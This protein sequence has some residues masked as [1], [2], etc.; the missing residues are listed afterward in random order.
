MSESEENLSSA[1]DKFFGVKT[2]HGDLSAVNNSSDDSGIEV[3]V[4]QDASPAQEPDKK[5]VPL[6]NYSKDLTDEELASYSEGVQKRINQ[7]T[8]KLKNRESRLAEAQA[9]KDEAVRV[10]KIQQQKLQEYESLLTK[11]QGALIESSRQGA[12]CAG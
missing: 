2:Q 1:E 4:A 10:A 7:I 5:G 12:S 6:V 9:I 8:G 3:E 11:G